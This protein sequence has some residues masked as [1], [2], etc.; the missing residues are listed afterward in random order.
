MIQFAPIWGKNPRYLKGPYNAPESWDDYWACCAKVAQWKIRHKRRKPLPPR[1]K[2]VKVKELLAE[3]LLWAK[4]YYST[5]DNKEFNHYAN[6]ISPLRKRYADRPAK[7]I[8]PLR[9][10]RVRRDMIRK[11]WARKHVNAQ[12]N[13]LRAVFQWGVENELVGP[14]QLARLKAIRELRKGKTSAPERPPVAPVAWSDASQVLPYLSPMIATMVEL[15]YLTGMRSAELCAMTVEAIEFRA[16]VW[17][18]RPAVHK[19]EHRGKPKT[20][21]LGPQ[22]QSLLIPYLQLPSDERI[23]SPRRAVQERFAL[24]AATAKH[25]RYG[26]RK[27]STFRAS[28]YRDHYSTDRYYHAIGYGFDKH[29]RWRKREA[30][31]REVPLSEIPELPRWHPHQLRHTRATMTREQYGREGAESQTG[32]SVQA[33]EIYAERNL[34]LAIR[35]AVETG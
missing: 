28:R 18:Y 16:D 23:F 29:E 19:N 21:C 9:L 3:F 31:A 8:G 12:F 30:K 14:T 20:I 33:A 25:K 32:N 5:K 15:H 24:R 1:G 13:R 22:A 10:K 26:K 11:G 2:R 27:A 7:S 17:L 34:P 6:A 4:P 35:V